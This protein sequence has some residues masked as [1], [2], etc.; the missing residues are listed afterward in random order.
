M[1]RDEC[2]GLLRQDS[3]FALRGLHQRLDAIDQVLTR[4]D[5]LLRLLA[6][7]IESEFLQQDARQRRPGAEIS[8][9]GT[10]H[11]RD[12]VDQR[13]AGARLLQRGVRQ[14]GEFLVEDQ[15]HQ[16]ALV[17]GVVEQRSDT[18]VRHVRYLPHGRR[19]IAVALEQV[20]RRGAD[21]LAFFEL[22]PVAKAECAHGIRF[23]GGCGFHGGE[24]RLTADAAGKIRD[25]SGS[26]GTGRM[27]RRIFAGSGFCCN[28]SSDSMTRAGIFA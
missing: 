16:V 24:A 25:P 14:R 1:P 28:A 3:P 17:V 15:E 23:V 9:V 4:F 13:A 19:G 5:K 20:R 22:V 11:R 26:A 10:K 12:L 2:R 21:A 7:R 27:I 8:V 18:D 6:H